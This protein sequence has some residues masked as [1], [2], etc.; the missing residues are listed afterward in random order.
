M[1]SKREHFRFM[2][3]DYKNIFFNKIILS[4]LMCFI[5]LKES[6]NLENF[7]LKIWYKHKMY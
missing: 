5:I 7:V 1:L 6:F 4:N 2:K 3:K